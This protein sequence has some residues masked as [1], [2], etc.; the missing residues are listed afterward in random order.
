MQVDFSYIGKLV[1]SALNGNDYSFSELYAATYKKQY[2]AALSYLKDEHLAQDALQETYVIA[3]EN[4]SKLTEPKLFISWLNKI[5]VNVCYKMMNKHKM[6]IDEL[7]NYETADIEGISSS[8]SSSSP[9]TDEIEEREKKKIIIQK[10]QSLPHNEFQTLFLHFYRNK[11]LDEVAAILGC[12]RSSV[13]RYLL[14]GKA[15]L[16]KE[17]ETYRKEV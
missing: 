3:F 11:T 10:L 8:S 5:N 15:R 4:L 16:K 2:A 14:S 12:S 9:V 17:L 7:S 1:E 6:D 13:K